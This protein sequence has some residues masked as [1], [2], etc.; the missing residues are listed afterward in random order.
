MA[1][2]HIDF[3][4]NRRIMFTVSLVLL[5]VSVVALAGRG[6][7]LGIEFEGGT[8]IDVND[9]GAITSDE[10][11]AAF[12][13][14]G[15]P[16][17]A[18]QTTE[19]RGVNG[20]IIRTEAIDP[21]TGSEDAAVVA[22]KLGLP[23][24][25]FQVTV[26]GPD[27]GRDISRSSALAFV[28][29]IAAIVAYMSIRFEWKMSLTAIVA[30][31]HDLVI[32]VGVYALSGRPVTPNVIAALLTIL[33]YSL[34]DT[35]V[36]FHR[37]KDNAETLGKER[38]MDMANRSINEVFMRTVNTTLSSLIPVVC[39]LLLGGATLKDFAFAMSVGLVVGSYS[40]FA[41]AAPLYT[42]WKEREPRY[43]ALK[44]RDQAT[45]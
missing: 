28:I 27:W 45:S 40:S 29:S 5:L 44:R 36:V 18:V 7:N 43:A 2:F 11:A 25:A 31:L 20:F 30:L 3:L 37:I 6:L 10:M 32:V 22:D 13:E 24:D 33:G 1:R 38:F 34:Y 15:V 9:T 17:V 19:S 35:V 8:V 42:L 39:L 16:D 23:A 12:A 41:V 21:V 14:A 26:I 4:G